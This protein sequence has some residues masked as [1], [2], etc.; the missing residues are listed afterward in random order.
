M[1][2]IF[3]KMIFGQVWGSFLSCLFIIKFVEVILKKHA[4]FLRVTHIVLIGF[5]LISIII[6]G[7]IGNIPQRGILSHACH[8]STQEA[9]ADFCELRAFLKCRLRSCLEIP[10]E[11]Q[12]FLSNGNKGNL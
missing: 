11:R 12:R 2:Y 5:L 4:G 9:E 8:P 10:M 1:D 7:M 6:D 3:L